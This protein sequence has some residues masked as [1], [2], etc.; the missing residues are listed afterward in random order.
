M[1]ITRTHLARL[2]TLNRSL[3]RPHTFSKARVW[4]L[5]LF[6]SWTR[7]LG[8]YIILIMI[9][10]FWKADHRLAREVWSPA[11]LAI[12]AATDQVG[13]LRVSVCLRVVF[14]MR[15]AKGRKERGV[16]SSSSLDE[17]FGGWMTFPLSPSPPLFKQRETM[18]AQSNST[19]H[20]SLVSDHFPEQVFFPL[21]FFFFELEKRPGENK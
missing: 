20:Y 9:S 8:S 12:W 18:S 5:P 6:S 4:S 21:F 1:E 13:P 3:H 2:L 16:T 15:V 11:L 19:L 7:A 17:K 14:A 10:R